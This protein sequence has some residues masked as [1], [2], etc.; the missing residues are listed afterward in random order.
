[1]SNCLFDSAPSHAETEGDIVTLGSCN[2][3]ASAVTHVVAL[4]ILE[5]QETAPYYLC[6]G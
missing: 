1:M 6:A 5:L 2:G 3:L 4:K